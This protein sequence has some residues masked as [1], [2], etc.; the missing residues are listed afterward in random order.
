MLLQL[1]A[2]DPESLAKLCAETDKLP[3]PPKPDPED[4]AYIFYTSGTTGE[5]KGVLVAHRTTEHRIACLAPLTGLRNGADLRALGAAPLFHAIGFYLVFMVTLAYNG[6]YYTMSAF[7][8]NLLQNWRLVH[9]ESGRSRVCG[10]RFP[11]LLWLSSASF[12]SFRLVE[13]RMLVVRGKGA[14]RSAAG[15]A[16]WQPA[17]LRPSPRLSP[18]IGVDRA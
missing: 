15:F 13:R 14:S 4:I 1:P 10:L 9:P 5:P 11:G 7:N 16:R 3:P 8:P 12:L 17:A 6:T 18:A 2:G